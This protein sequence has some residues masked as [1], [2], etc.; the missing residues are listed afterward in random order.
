MSLLA[1][2]VCCR[3]LTHTIDLAHHNFH[4]INF[5]FYWVDPSSRFDAGAY[6]PSNFPHREAAW[7]V[8]IAWQILLCLPTFITIVMPESPRWLVLKGR[9]EE[10]RKVMASLD[11]IDINDKEIDVKIAEIKASLNAAA[12][13]GL[14]DLIIQGPE[15]N[16]H[17]TALGFIIQ[18][19]Q[20]ISGINLITYYAGTL[21]ETQLGFDAT[22][23]RIMAACNGTEYFLASFVA[24]FTIERFGRRN[25]MLFG[26]AGQVS[27][28]A[29]TRATC[30]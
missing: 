15:R 28:M 14:K 29:A 10:A 5:A 23:S 17:R 12:K 11:E 6:D 8:P 24:V 2:A 19:F 26:A 13:V 25:L 4:R 18:M 9:E 30:N 22:V 20:Q 27:D 16:F 21:Y 3:P 1:L 7:R